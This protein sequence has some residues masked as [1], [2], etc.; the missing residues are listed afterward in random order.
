MNTPLPRS[1]ILRLAL[2]GGLGFWTANLAI[3]LTPIAAEYRTALSIPY[4]P[5]LLEALVGGVVIGTAVALLVARFPGASSG[6]HPMR[7]ALAASIAALVVVTV[8][9]EAPSKL[10]LATGDAAHWFLVGAAFNVVR[11]SALGLAVGVLYRVLERPI[12][13][14][15]SAQ[16][17][18]SATADGRRP[19]TSAAERV[20]AHSTRVSRT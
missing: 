19:S 13:A 6:G 9:I 20:A 12:P 10:M 7:T 5:M 2:A 18:R 8:L 15:A 4:L 17:A 16:A 14:G 11:F 3:S 1:D